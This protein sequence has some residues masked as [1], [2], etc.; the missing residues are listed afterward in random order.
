MDESRRLCSTAHGTGHIFLGTLISAL[1]VSIVSAEPCDHPLTQA[2]AGS[3]LISELRCT[4]F[5]AFAN[6]L[7][8]QSCRR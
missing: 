2:Q 7:G 8:A 5:P 1:L 3:L 6:L 4:A